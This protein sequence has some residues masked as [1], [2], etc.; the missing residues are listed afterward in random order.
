MATVTAGTPARTMRRTAEGS[1]APE[2][3]SS[4]EREDRDPASSRPFLGKKGSDRQQRQRTAKEVKEARGTHQEGWRAKRC[5]GTSSV[6]VP[7]ETKASNT[8][9]DGGGQGSRELSDRSD[10]KGLGTGP[11]RPQARPWGKERGNPGPM[12]LVTSEYWTATND[13]R[14][15]PRAGGVWDGS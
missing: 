2:K 5:S 14:Q 8:P 3:H 13:R 10:K 6:K 9:G 7:A 15:G 11:D 12:G 1:K 4:A